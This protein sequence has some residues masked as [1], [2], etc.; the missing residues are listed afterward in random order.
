VKNATSVPTASSSV[1]NAFW[2]ALEDVRN[3][4]AANRPSMTPVTNPYASPSLHQG[5]SAT[6]GPPRSNRAPYYIINGVFIAL[7]G[8]LMS[9][10][11]LV[12]IGLTV[13]VLANLPQNVTIDYLRL[14]AGI[15]G[16]ILGI[17]IGAVMAL[18]GI[19]MTFRSDL[20]SARNAAILA[21]IPCFGGCVFP[22]G[23]WAAFLLYARRAESDFG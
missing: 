13:Y 6:A 4:E 17:I 9:L 16:A 21:A 5:G 12:Q 14:T 19:Q 20:S 15:V 1:G 11:G 7:W 10:S 3:S 18:G 23:I 22:F 2:D 8:L